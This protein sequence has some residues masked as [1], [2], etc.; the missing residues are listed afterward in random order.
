MHAMSP[1]N[2]PTLERAMTAWPVGLANAWSEAL[3]VTLAALGI[4]A[5]AE[6]QTRPPEGYEGFYLVEMIRL[7]PQPLPQRVL[8]TLWAFEAINGWESE[9]AE[10]QARERWGRP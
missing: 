10:E 1:T 9:N 2:L 7:L 3:E 6:L 5:P 8:D 4:D